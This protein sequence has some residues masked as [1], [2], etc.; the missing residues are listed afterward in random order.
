M[1]S[2]QYDTMFESTMHLVLEDQ[3]GRRRF[4]NVLIPCFWAVLGSLLTNLW[5]QGMT[6]SDAPEASGC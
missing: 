5:T 1:G 3:S 4:S 6:G 2:N